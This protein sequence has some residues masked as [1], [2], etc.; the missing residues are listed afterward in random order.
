MPSS[1]PVLL[2]VHFLRFVIC[3][4]FYACGGRLLP[5]GSEYGGP[6]RGH[7]PVPVELTVTPPRTVVVAGQL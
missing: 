5:T 1:Q 6:G 3:V 2:A 7:E 4:L